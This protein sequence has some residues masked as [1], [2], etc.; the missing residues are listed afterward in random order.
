MLTDLTTLVD[1]LG[2]RVGFSLFISCNSSPSISVTISF[3]LNVNFSVAIDL[4]DSALSGLLNHF[5]GWQ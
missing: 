2:L 4:T 3:N 1:L 5:G